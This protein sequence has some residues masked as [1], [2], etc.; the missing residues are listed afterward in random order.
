[1]HNKTKRALTGMGFAVATVV[2]AVGANA[3]T[4]LWDFQGGAS[5]PE[6]SVASGNVFLDGSTAPAGLT[7]GF[8]IRLSAY[9]ATTAGD[10][11]TLNPGG[12]TPQGTSGIGMT[13]PTESTTAPQHAIDS[14]S[15]NREF[16]VIDAWNGAATG[17][18]L[19]W[20]SLKIGYGYD[21]YVGGTPGTAGQF[22]TGQADIKVWAL[23]SLPTTV[24]GLG[25]GNLLSNLTSN[26]LGNLDGTCTGTGSTGTGCTTAQGLNIGTSRYLVIAGDV[27]DAFKLK[28]IGATTGSPP[29]QT[30]EPASLGLLGLGLLGLGYARR[31]RTA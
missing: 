15:P 17:T 4:Y 6:T 7:S 23:N 2:F 31:R 18:N 10:S 26:A 27:N 8:N 24:S 25:T 9:Y 29:N 14:I 5:T 21:T 22:T 28:Q 12:F 3:A 13:S 11:L 16:V 1:M 19:N 20:S 30:P